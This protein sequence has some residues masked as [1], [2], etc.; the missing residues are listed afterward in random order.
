M[1]DFISPL[2]VGQ[3]TKSLPEMK[4]AAAAAFAEGALAPYFLSRSS[5][6]RIL[7]TGVFGNSVRNSITLGC[8]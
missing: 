4:K 8:L 2:F 1:G 6:R 3:D 7:P 5:R